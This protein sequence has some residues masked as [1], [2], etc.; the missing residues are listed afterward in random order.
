MKKIKIE[1][2]VFSIGGSGDSLEKGA[3]L[4]KIITGRTPARMQSRKRIPAFGVRPKLEVG[5]VVTVRK[6]VE[7]VLK[8]MLVTKENVLRRASISENCFS[9][10]VKEYIEIP[11]MEYQR[12]I[13]IRGLDV[14][15]TFARA[16]KR[17]RLKKIKQ[18]KIPRRNI[19]TKEEIIKFMEE[20]FRTKFV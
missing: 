5:A 3:K 11:G 20:K 1:K 10:G 9:F 19:I 4:L 15:V 6:N 14:T 2:V 8:R 12:D 17:V 18:G 13:G 16:G 7:E